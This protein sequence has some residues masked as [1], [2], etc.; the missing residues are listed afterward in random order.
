M[1][2]YAVAFKNQKKTN[3]TKLVFYKTKKNQRCLNNINIIS[4][5]NS[6][7]SK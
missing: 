1:G 2:P 5:S 3:K 7:S 6:I 4:I